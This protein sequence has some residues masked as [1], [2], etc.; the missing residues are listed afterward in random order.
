MREPAG[1]RERREFGVV[2]ID[3]ERRR[4]HA[5]RGQRDEPDQAAALASQANAWRAAPPQ[6]VQSTVEQKPGRSLAQAVIVP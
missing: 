4:E 2:T 3:D 1:V 6:A 5:V